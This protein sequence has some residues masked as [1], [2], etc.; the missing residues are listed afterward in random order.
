[1]DKQK[2]SQLGSEN[3]IL[4]LYRR[5]SDA[6]EQALMGLLEDPLH[7][8]QWSFRSLEEL[9]ALLQKQSQAGLA[10]IE[11]GERR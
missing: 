1:M 8:R 4:R 7:G 5:E 10:Q 9:K 2:H 3:Y 6:S 11:I